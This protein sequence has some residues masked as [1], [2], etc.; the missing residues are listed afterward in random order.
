[1]VSRM[2]EFDDLWVAYSRDRRPSNLG[3]RVNGV[4]IGDLDDEIQDVAGSYAAL[5]GKLGTWRAARL[6]LALAEVERILPRLEPAETVAYFERL[7]AL[8]R[9][10][11][12]EIASQEA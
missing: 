12:A 7:A 11:L 8:A 10:A 9:A 6:G 4:A 3:A 1:M 2:A 5:R